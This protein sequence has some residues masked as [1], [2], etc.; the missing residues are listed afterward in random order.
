MRIPRCLAAAASVVL[1]AGCAE[2]LDVANP[3]HPDRPRVLASP[4]EVESLAAAQF[5]QVIQG[6]VGMLGTTHPRMMSWGLEQAN[7]L[8]NNAMGPGASIPRLPVDNSRG[9]PYQADNF[10]TYRFLSFVTRNTADVLARAKAE[11]FDLGA[12]RAGDRP[13]LI[14]WAHFVS[15]VAHGYLSLT[16]DSAAIARPA[17]APAAVP[18]LSGYAEVNAYAMSQFDSALVYLNVPGVSAL[19]ASWLQGP[20]ATGAL[21]PA[22]FQRV[23]RSFRARLRAGV[24]RNPAERAAVNWAAVIDDAINGITSDLTI[25][26]RPASGWDFTW[27]AA[28]LHFRDANWH[29]AQNYFIGMADVSGAYDAWLAADRDTRPHFTIVTPDRRFPRGATRAEQNRPAALD[30]APLPAGQYFRNRLPAKD[31]GTT[32][33]MNSQYDHYRFRQFSNDARIGAFPWFT[34][35]ENDMLAAEGYIRRGQ[36][37]QAAALIDITRTRNGLPALSGVVTTATQPVPGGANCVPRVPQPPTFTR[38]ACGNIMEAMKWEKRMETAFTTFGAWYFDGRGWGDL[39][40][41]TPIHF[42]VPVQELDARRLPIYNLGGVGR[43][44][45]SGPST[46]GFGSGNR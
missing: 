18:P 37:A 1:L 5:Q 40:E 26:M 25:M 23:V 22:E 10:A 6:T 34:K 43:E 28:T 32:G 24:A 31:A 27:L 11:G 8:A 15:G 46:Y 33:W 42:P 13:R 35:A 36:I 7:G 20:D 16:Y 9:N 44:G 29:Q 14:A 2:V 12:G 17:D 3:N 39:P 30:D 38:T 19:P 4:P 45:G 21:T 41:G